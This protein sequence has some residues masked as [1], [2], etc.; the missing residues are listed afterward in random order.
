[1]KRSAMPPR[2]TWLRRSGKR[3]WSPA[4]NP[5]QAALREQCFDRD[6]WTCRARISPD[7]TPGRNLHPHHVLP[8]GR[9]GRDELSNLVTLC[10][11]CHARAH[12][13][14]ADA[15]RAGWLR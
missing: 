14:P 11:A 12:A 8:R 7:C 3:A 9:G 6:D 10:A 1:M 2:R 4:T 15:R 13:A 5:V